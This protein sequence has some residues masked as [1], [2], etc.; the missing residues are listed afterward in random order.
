MITHPEFEL[1]KECAIPELNTRAALYRH[2][3]TGAE[4][5]SLEND[6][7]NKMFG[8]AFRTPPSDST[9]LPH[10]MEHSVLCGSRKYPVKEPF[11][12]LAKGSLNTFLNAFTFN[13]KTCYPV[14]SQNLQD[15]Y[16]L[17]GVYL[18]AVFYPHIT[19]EVL[20]Q[21]GWHYELESLDAPLTYKGVVFN[22]MKGA[23][24]SPDN[25]A[26]R[27]SEQSLFPDHVYGHDAGGDPEVIPHLT[28]AQF[29]NFHETYYHPSNARFFFYGDDD[30]AKRLQ[31]TQDYLKDFA[32]RPV[33]SAIALQPAMPTPRR[34]TCA[35]PVSEDAGDAKSY[36]SMNWLLPENNDP[37]LTLALEILSHALVGTP[38]SPLRKTLIDSGLGED[39]IGGGTDDSLRQLTFSTGMKGV[40]GE[41]VDQVVTLILDTLAGLAQTGLDPD[42]IAASVNTLEFQL[43]EQNFGSYPR[44]L[45][46]ML[47]ALTTWLHDG[48][49][50]APIA[51]AAPLNAVKTQLAADPRFLETMIQTYLLDNTHRTVV[52]LAPDAVLQQK[53]E[54]AEKTR[55]AQARASMDEARLRTILADAQRLKAMQ[56]APNSPE[57]LATIPRLQLS[58]LDKRTKPVPTEIS[59][60][61]GTRLLY[62]NLFTNGILYLDLGLNLHALPQE[63]LPYAEMFGEALL[64]IGTETEDFVK[65]TLRIGQK[66]GGIGTVT[67]HTMPRDGN[68]SASWLF[69]R[70][71]ATV[72]QSAELLAI[73]RDILLTVKLDNPSRFIQMLLENKAGVEAALTPAGH[74]MAAS[75]LRAKFNE[76]A[77]ASEQ[78]SGVSYLFFLRDLI[79]QAEK[80]WPTVLARLEE[81]RR[82]L[83]NRA[84]MVCNVTLDADNWAAVRPQVDT[85]LEALPAARAATVAWTPNYQLD[86]EG[87]TIP[88]KIN[89]VAKGANLFELGYT[90]HG[91][92]DVIANCM[93]TSW[94]WDK[95]R[96][97]GGAYGVWG[98]FD[99]HSGIFTYLSYRDPNLLDT[100]TAYDGTVAFLRNLDLP[101]EELVKNI[102]GAVGALDAYQLPDAKG[103]SALLRYLIGYSDEAR[104]QH[105]DEVLSTTL[106]DFKRLANVLEKLNTAGSVVVLGTQEAIEKA[107]A[108]GS[109]PFAMTKVL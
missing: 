76:A 7:E 69:L 55:L 108:E 44:G 24:S 47:R 61:H 70:G 105:R 98:M 60:S 28:Y 23:Y 38:A 95:V 102:I 109:I 16:N 30:P 96:V 94:L 8:V 62:H 92:M 45:V 21:E 19:P 22:E 17:V 33:D 101:E 42:T 64:N 107:G 14:A 79:A 77:W 88:A 12:E 74:R 15:F 34:I 58:D 48:D 72:A 68:R 97:Q 9:G 80:D 54:A 32:A 57:A 20:Q 66:T 99:P 18:D 39:L 85:F 26:A 93:R 40:K 2:R 27:Y 82:L 25:L 46:V 43:R 6:D 91:S 87:L 63:L 11:I 37:T 100:L 106:A 71:K 78:M 75:R 52:V 49:P 3:A 65:L 59:D 29:K 41:N 1:I 50:F 36:V 86:P 4:L 103:F 13:D 51:F 10:I 5:L 89:Y 84:M 83:V 73:L 35:Y 81:V 56:E 31:L 90:R 67:A 104:Q 53:Q